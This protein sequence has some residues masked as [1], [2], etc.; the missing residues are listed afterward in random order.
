M[1]EGDNLTEANLQVNGPREEPAQREADRQE[2]EGEDNFPHNSLMWF[3][4]PKAT[5][6]PSQYEL[7]F[8]NTS[9]F[10]R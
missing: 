1:I 3:P 4:W 5:Y 2:L 6:M 10:N 7:L 9:D 8:I